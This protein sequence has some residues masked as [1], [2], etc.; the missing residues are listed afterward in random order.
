[1]GSRF[2]IALLMVLAWTGCETVQFYAQAVHGHGQILYRQKPITELLANPALES[3]LSNQ[4]SLVLSLREFAHTR[5]GLPAEKQYLKYADLE[6]AHVVW[7]V[8]AAPEFSLKPKTWWYPVVGSLSYRGY[9]SKAAA[10]ACADQ[11]KAAGYDVFV[12]GVEAYSTLGWFNDPVLNTFI[13]RQDSDLADLIFHELAHQKLFVRGDTDFNEAFATT[14]A[15]EGVRRWLTTRDDPEWL[16][17]WRATQE[18]DDA[19]VGLILRTRE[20]LEQLY[21]ERES[22]PEPPGEHNSPPG[23][24]E[25]SRVRSEKL[26]IFQFMRAEYENLKQDWGGWGGY[27]AWFSYPVN[28]ARLNAEAT[29]YEKVPAFQKLL[30][31]FDGDLDLFYDGVRLLGELPPDQR[32]HLLTSSPG[33][34]RSLVELKQKRM[35]THPRPPAVLKASQQLAVLRRNAE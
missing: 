3:G 17:E 21:T 30:A 4:L 26:R 34:V 23:L 9:F 32:M 15:R 12:G 35:L 25:P 2:V 6:R 19:F 13:H 24:E 31:E 18:Q 10:Q 16:L 20:Q 1:M 11:L 27:D 28:N 33:S 5:L 7:D 29:Y 14:V 22:L 8:Y